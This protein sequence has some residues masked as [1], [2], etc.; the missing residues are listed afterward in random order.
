MKANDAP[1][2]SGLPV[3]GDVLSGKYAVARKIGEGGM[4]VVYEAMH[5]RLRQRIAIKVLRPDV[6]DDGRLLARFEREAWVTAQLR[7]RHT[8]RV[9][10]VD[11][12]PNGLPYIVLEYL[13]GRDLDAELT[14]SG[15][16]PVEEA[17]D[18]VTQV[19]EAMAE[20]HELGIVHRDIKPSNLFVCRSGGRRVV[21]ILDFG[22]SRVEADATRL[23]LDDAYVGTPCYASPEQLRDSSSADARSDVWSL[24]IVLYELLVGHPPFVGPNTQVIA[25]VM[26]DSVPWPGA[27]RPDVPRDLS[28]VALRALRRNPSER[29]QTM[30]EF[31]AA[32]S[33]F[34]PSESLAQAIAGASRGRLGEILV[35]DG[36]VTKEQLDCALAEQ[37]AS[38]K[39]L[40]RAL[41]DLG[42]VTRADMLVALA[43]QQGIGS[44][45]VPDVIARERVERDA[46][47]SRGHASY[48]PPTALPRH[49][50]VVLAAVVWLGSLVAVFFAR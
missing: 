34:G 48:R 32:L 4:G 43:K 39:L 12:L 21:K 15:P 28:L 7:S 19:A 44:A 40:G 36:L 27:S 24:G 22:I 20:A 29:F 17:V 47:T 30:R 6:L 37:K 3:P 45:S 8:A 14:A 35:A 9:V 38:G 50:W 49:A 18:L 41:L 25:R 5:L 10:D 31:A 42:F 23:T 13:E 16:L 2:P 26:V 1:A 11:R 33:P 46:L